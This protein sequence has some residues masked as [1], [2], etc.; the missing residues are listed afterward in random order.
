MRHSFQKNF[1]ELQPSD[2]PETLWKSLK[3]TVTKVA[4]ELV[5]KRKRIKKSHW[6]IKKTVAMAEEKRKTK[7]TEGRSTN[8]KEMSANIQ[9]ESRK[10]K[11]DSLQG[12]CKEMEARSNAKYTAEMFRKIKEMTGNFSSSRGSLKDENEE[13]QKRWT[14]YTEK[15]Y[16]RDTSII[17]DFRENDFEDEAQITE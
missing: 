12:I 16:L 13:I 6:L 10:D 14:K 11:N 15:L 7:A 3:E 4:N 2:N 17:C 8:Y 9:R 5:P 1:S